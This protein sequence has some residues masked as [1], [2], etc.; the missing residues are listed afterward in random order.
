MFDLD[1]IIDN[2]RTFFEEKRTAAIVTAIVI[3]LFLLGLI[4]MML[5]LNSKP[6][7]PKTYAEPPFEAD[8]KIILPEGPSVPD[9]YAVT[10]E[11][12]EKWTEQ[13]SRENFTL[14]DNSALNSLKN[15]N[16]KIVNEILGAAP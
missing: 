3:L 11:L 9:G 14:P 16:D 2:I 4:G 15:S 5:Y 13:E 1:G 8:Q 6:A 10:R 12:S 7:G